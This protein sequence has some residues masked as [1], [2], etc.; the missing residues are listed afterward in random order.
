MIAEIKSMETV[1]THM[2]TG[3]EVGRVLTIKAKLCEDGF[4]HIQIIK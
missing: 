3:D 4:I 2:V 1:S